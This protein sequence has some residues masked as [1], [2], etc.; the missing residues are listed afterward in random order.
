MVFERKLKSDIS[1]QISSCFKSY[2]QE[3]LA[4]FEE[5][6]ASNREVTDDRLL[7]CIVYLSKG[8]INILCEVIDLAEKD[9][10]D[11][12]W[13]AEYDCDEKGLRDFSAPFEA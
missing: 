7:R 1:K 5:F 6:V 12:I 4:L 3:A 2:S 8:D 11:L 10:R 9:F 13:S